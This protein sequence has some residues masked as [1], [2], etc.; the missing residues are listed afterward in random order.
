MGLFQRERWPGYRKGYQHAIGVILQGPKIPLGKE[1]SQSFRTRGVVL[2]GRLILLVPL[3]ALFAFVEP[4]ED[5]AEAATWGCT[6]KDI[7]P[8]NDIDS[9]INNDPSGTATTF[10]VDAGTY[11]VS[12]PAILKAGDKLIGQPG[13]KPFVQK[14]T[15]GSCV[16]TNVPQ[17]IPVVKLVGSGTDN[18]LR[19]RGNPIFISWVDLTGAKGTGN[20]SG[21][22]TAGSAGSDFVVEFARIHDNASL[23][24]SNMQG[25]V[26]DSEFFRN[27]TAQS[28]LGFNGS[29]VKGI[30]EYEAARVFVHD[31]QGNGLWCDV[32]CKNSARTT[33]TPKCPTGCFWVHHS[34]VVNSGRAGI[35]YEN[36]PNDA[37]FENNEIHA[38]SSDTTRGGI[39][40]RD[41]QNATVES[42]VFGGATF[43][44]ID[45]LNKLVT[46]TYGPNTNN[47]RIGVRA[48]DSGR[49]D[50]VNLLNVIVRNNTMNNE[51]IIG[52]DDRRVV[53]S[54]NS[55]L[56]TK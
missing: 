43:R 9:I 13:T 45:P 8:G 48:T 31:E 7:K 53:C 17:P 42:N 41:S 51:R 40:I 6:G 56:G 30:T 21:A 12:A 3:L 14:C 55:G 18:L 34:V 5:R 33:M 27:S 20:G 36:S 26:R 28:A 23:G 4:T 37:L 54:N 1:L 22:I 39:D 25:T 52:C 10:C 47:Q 16:N 15:A 11:Q 19:A 46:M 38:N 49:S 24:I 29:A 2:K 44:F 32:G 50:R 35:R